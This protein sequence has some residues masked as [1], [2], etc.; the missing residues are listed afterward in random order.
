AIHWAHRIGAV[1]VL[2]VTL[3]TCLQVYKVRNLR[4]IAL[5]L[6]ILLGIQIALGVTNVLASLPLVS[7]VA[8]NGVAALLLAAVTMLNF[9]VRSP[10]MYSR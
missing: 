1:V 2:L 3:L 9:A 10:S 7:A 4:D 8:H 6:L 5:T